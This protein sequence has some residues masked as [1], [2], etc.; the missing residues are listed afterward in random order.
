MPFLSPNQKYKSIEGMYLCFHQNVC[1]I[2]HQSINQSTELHTL[3][4]HW[5]YKK[6]SED[7]HNK[8]VSVHYG[9]TLAK[10]L[11]QTQRVDL[12]TGNIHTITSFK[13][14]LTETKMLRGETANVKLSIFHLKIHKHDIS[15]RIIDRNTDLHTQLLRF[16]IYIFFVE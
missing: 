4:L 14:L 6:L 10:H 9:C 2:V 5:R 13:Q 16:W 15:T 12:H 11:K 7:R 1:T 3:S 8:L